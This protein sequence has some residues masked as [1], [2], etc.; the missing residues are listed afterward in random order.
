MVTPQRSQ[1]LRAV[2]D[3]RIGGVTVLLDA[4]HDPHN[5]AA[6]LRSADAFGIPELHVVTRR[7][8]FLAS[9]VV[10][11]GTERWVDVVEHMTAPAAARHLTER[12]YE[13][14]TTHPRGELLPEDLQ[15]IPRLAVVM[16]NEH[17]GICHELQQSAGRSVRIPMI[18]FVESLNL[19]VSAAIL[20]REATR[21]RPAD[22][23]SEARLELYAQGLFRSV[24]QARLVLSALAPA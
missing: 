7:H 16:G 2:M 8:A 11:R 17:D 10:A 24:K 19:S 3:S 6:I 21:A 4:P 13:L 18:G 1:R 15:Q 5:G 14:V 20:L 23:S 22:L 9:N 12:G